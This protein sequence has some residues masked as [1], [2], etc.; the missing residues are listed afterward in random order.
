MLTFVVFLT[1]EFLLVIAF[2]NTFF[3]TFT[4]Y[5]EQLIS[6]TEAGHQ[7]FDSVLKEC[8]LCLR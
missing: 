8:L 7:L 2:I 5:N 4:I 1:V 6:Y 3:I